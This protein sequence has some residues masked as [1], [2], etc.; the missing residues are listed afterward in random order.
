MVTLSL[1]L[2]LLKAGLGDHSRVLVAKTLG[3]TERNL[4][5]CFS[6]F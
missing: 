6:I 2:P 4:R 3:D 5:V 1:V